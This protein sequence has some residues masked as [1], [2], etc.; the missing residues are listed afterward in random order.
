M[1]CLFYDSN[2]NV[3][4]TT[5]LRVLIIVITCSNI[6]FSNSSIGCEVS[7]EVWE[8]KVQKESTK[9]VLSKHISVGKYNIATVI[10]WGI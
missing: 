6:F 1:L 4:I 2:N 8:E 3:I 9:M 7:S 5:V 10:K